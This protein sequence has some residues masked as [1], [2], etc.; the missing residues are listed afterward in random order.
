[1]Q[2]QDNDTQSPMMNRRSFACGLAAV[3]GMSFIPNEVLAAIPK[4][5]RAALVKPARS[6]AFDNLHTSAN[7]RYL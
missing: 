6:L 4:G 5:N 3:A 1:M 2:Q 7:L